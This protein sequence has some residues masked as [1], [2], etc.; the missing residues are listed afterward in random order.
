MGI[1]NIIQRICVQTAV[2]WGAPEDDGYGGKDFDSIYPIEIA[3][4]WEEKTELI[5]RI[6]AR[7]GEELISNA[8]VS[9][10]QDVDEQGYLYLG[11]LDNLDSDQEANPET[12]DDAYSIKKFEKIPSLGST[13]EFVRKAYL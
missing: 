10:T 6:G 9:V 1:E 13:N 5:S 8:Q 2:Y 4:R 7:L 11:T 12:I 3:C